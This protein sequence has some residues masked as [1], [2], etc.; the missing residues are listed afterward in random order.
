MALIDRLKRRTRQAAGSLLGDRPAAPEAPVPAPGPLPAPELSPRPDPPD[1]AR[2]HV[3]LIL[4]SL[5]YDALMAARP[6]NLLR[7]GPIERRYSYATWTAPSH[8]NLLMG[9]LPHPSPRQVFASE[10]YKEDFLRFRERLG[11]PELSWTGMV[12]QLWLPHHLR[13]NLGYRTCAQVSMPVLNP[14]T[15]LAVGFDRYELAEKHNDL[16]A[17]LDNV[18][19][20]PDR[21]TWWLLNT[22][23]THYPYATPEEPEERWP[24]VHGVNGVFRQV[25]AGQPLSAADSPR[26]FDEGRMDLLRRRQIR[27]AAHVDGVL[28]KLFDLVPP[29][30]WI[31]VTS[32]HG[33]L[34]GEEGYFGH[35][36]IL[37]DKVME[38]PFVEGL[39]R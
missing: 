17:L 29:G 19:W 30:T 27:A 11:I 34:F 16:S 1:G 38:V 32:D 10:H 36:P 12:P 22:G 25:A 5:R 6:K 31:T 14:R 20:R 18:D 39:L 21:P 35:G 8:Y 15:P 26:F 37:H 4:D 28:E 2:N 9:L 33:E 3:L 7:L 13:D 24:R 23:E